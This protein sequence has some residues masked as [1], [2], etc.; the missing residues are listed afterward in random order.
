MEETSILVDMYKEQ[1]AQSRHH[2]VLR[3][4]VS[5]IIIAI[6]AGLLGLITYDKQVSTYDLPMIIFLITVG[7]LGYLI[8]MKQ[9]QHLQRHLERANGFAEKIEE[10][11]PSTEISKIMEEAKI[12][13]LKEFPVLS[14]VRLNRFWGALHIIIVILGLL[15]LLKVVLP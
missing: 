1:M 8:T 6:S 14:K 9:Y 7:V 2:E 13:N 5:N 15:L 3:A 12:R 11:H 4:T 10:L